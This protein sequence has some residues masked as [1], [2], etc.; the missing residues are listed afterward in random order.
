MLALLIVL[1]SEINSYVVVLSFYIKM[2]KRRT[3]RACSLRHR[4][5]WTWTCLSGAGGSPPPL[6]LPPPPTWLRACDLLNVLS[7]FSR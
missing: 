7:D 2:M 6:P 4:E 1:L 5:N 3:L